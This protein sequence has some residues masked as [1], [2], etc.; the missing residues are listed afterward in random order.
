MSD[1]AQKLNDKMS[2]KMSDDELDN[3]AGGSFAQNQDILVAMGNIDPEG[4]KIFLKTG[5]KELKVSSKIS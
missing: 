1:D 4:V 3:V 5:V 2:A